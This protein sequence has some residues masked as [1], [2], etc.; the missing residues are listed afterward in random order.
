MGVNGQPIVCTGMSRSLRPSQAPQRSGA[1]TPA[2]RTAPSMMAHRAVAIAADSGGSALWARQ[3]LIYS[4][5]YAGDLDAVTPHYLALVNG[6][7]DSDEPFWRVYGLGIEAISL[8]MFG[9]LEDANRRVA[10]ALTLAHRVGNP[11]CINWAFYTL[12]RVLAASDPL[13]VCEAFEQ[14]MRAARE[15]GSRFERQSQPR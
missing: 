7:R 2:T 15:V 12:G 3:A 6:I 14:A 8:T 10:Q 9:M 4:L 13:G 5:G 1:G 11:D